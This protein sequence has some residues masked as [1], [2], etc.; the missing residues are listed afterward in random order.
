MNMKTYTDDSI[1]LVSCHQK[2]AIE[3]LSGGEHDELIRSRLAL[4]DFIATKDAEIEALKAAN[5]DLHFLLRVRLVP[6]SAA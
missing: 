2:A 6:P 4:L 3:L 5:E 1:E